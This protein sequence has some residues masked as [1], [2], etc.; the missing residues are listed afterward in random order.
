M[1]SL[2][3]QGI[4]S[5]STLL[6]SISRPSVDNFSFCFKGVVVSVPIEAGEDP[7]FAD[8]F[9]DLVPGEEIRIAVQGLAGRK[10]QARWLCD[11][12]RDGFQL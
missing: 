5:T 2:S 12:E 4:S 10:V 6:I 11:W 3:L 1:S 9:V 7:E 8:N